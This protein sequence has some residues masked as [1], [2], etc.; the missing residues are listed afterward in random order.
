[1]FLK[2][3]VAHALSESGVPMDGSASLGDELPSSTPGRG[4][5]I[6]RRGLVG[7]GVVLAAFVIVGVLAEAV[8]EVTE[9]SPTARRTAG[10]T[11]R[12]SGAST[13]TTLAADLT[14]TL[15]TTATTRGVFVPPPA[16]PE[17]GSAQIDATPAGP[18]Q[19]RLV[20]SSTGGA[21]VTVSGPN[22]SSSARAGTVTVCY[23]TIA[24]TGCGAPA[25]PAPYTITVYGSG[26][27]VLF[28]ASDA[29]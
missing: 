17:T 20:W 5:R 16:A 25:N 8:D 4:R 13:S 26:G 23:G 10:G 2:N 18:F 9:T 19:A 3:K 15:A 6:A 22:F 7:A 14:T 24:R 28:Q 1:M 29:P 27:Q 12:T 11:T 21:S